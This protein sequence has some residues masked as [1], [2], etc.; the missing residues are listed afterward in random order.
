MTIPRTQIT[1]RGE[2][3]SPVKVAV[4]TKWIP[5][6]TSLKLNETVFVV[7]I[8]VTIPNIHCLQTNLLCMSSF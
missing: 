1:R 2:L 6:W 4:F 5:E 3:K 7:T 8:C